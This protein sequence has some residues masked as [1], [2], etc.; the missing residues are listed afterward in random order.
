MRHEFI[1]V[2]AFAN[3]AMFYRNSEMVKPLPLKEFI[4]NTAFYPLALEKSAIS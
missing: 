4:R 3:H 2:V 1:E